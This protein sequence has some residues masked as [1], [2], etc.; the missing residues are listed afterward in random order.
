MHKTKQTII[1][2]VAALVVAP[3]A[4]WALTETVFRYELWVTSTQSPA[5]LADDFGLAVLWV[6]V[7]LPGTTLCSVAA[8]WLTWR[9]LL[10]D[11]QK[12][13]GATH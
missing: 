13:G 3:I 1:A 5:E 10:R 9:R 6:M 12:C 4:H 2:L 11:P 8:A 7:V